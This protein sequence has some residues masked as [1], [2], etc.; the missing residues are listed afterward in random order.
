MFIVCVHHIGTIVVPC[1]SVL[2]GIGVVD[3]YFDAEIVRTALVQ[4]AQTVALRQIGQRIERFL[5]KTIGTQKT[6]FLQVEIGVVLTVLLDGL[7]QLADGH[8]HG[9]QR[10]AHKVVDND[11]EETRV[12][13]R[14][15][16]MIVLFTAQYRQRRE[17]V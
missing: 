16:G 8:L 7:V 3:G 15:V 14:I 6:V 11:V 12:Y 2:V 17:E 10:V 9:C 13:Q 4:F 5:I 1:P